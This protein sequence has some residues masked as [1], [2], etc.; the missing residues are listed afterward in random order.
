MAE[1]NAALVGCKDA[2]DQLIAAAQ[3]SG[4]AWTTPRAAGKWSPTQIVEHVARVLEESANV[5]AGRPSK[6]PKLPSVL[7]PVARRLLFERVLRKS[8]FPKGKTNRAMNPASGPATPADARVRLEGA[9]GK[10][11]AACREVASRGGVIR[12]SVFGA[13]GIED[14]VRFMELHTRHHIKQMGSAPGSR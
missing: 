13:V 7:H 12:S 6:F 10:F 3:S 11:S 2:T 9:Q 8:V 1:I 4:P 14:Y 5:V